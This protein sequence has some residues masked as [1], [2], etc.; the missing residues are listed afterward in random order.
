MGREEADSV[1]RNRLVEDKESFGQYLNLT[2][3]FS[4]AIC[5]VLVF[6][7]GLLYSHL[8]AQQQDVKELVTFVMLRDFT[9]C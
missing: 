9:A 7:S 1:F 3:I 6:K 4:T 5:S 2:L 8:T